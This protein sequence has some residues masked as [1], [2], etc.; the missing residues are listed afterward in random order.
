MLA[1][2]NAMATVA[3]KDLEVGR[4]FYGATLGLTPSGPES[5]EVALF[6][7][8]SS[9]IVVYRSELAGTNKATTATWGVGPELDSIVAALKRA[10]VTFEHYDFPGSQRDGDVHVFGDFRAVWFKDPD[11]NILHVNNG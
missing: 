1:D 7:S 3:V 8:G 6:K 2:K 11:G 4:A 5:S 10:G 9:T